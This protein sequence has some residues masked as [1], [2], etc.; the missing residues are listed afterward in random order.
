[1]FGKVN[2]AFDVEACTNYV[3][4]ECKKHDVHIMLSSDSHH[5]SLVGK[6]ETAIQ[7]VEETGYPEELIVNSSQE[8]LLEYLNGR[9]LK[10]KITL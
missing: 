8:R 3:I 2:R 5:A 9:P 10:N 6:F 4:D 1:M 7:L